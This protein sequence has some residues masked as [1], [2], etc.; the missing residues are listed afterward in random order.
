MRTKV[1]PLL[2]LGFLFVATGALYAGPRF[3]IGIGIG[4]PV[5]AYAPPPPPP[6]YGYGY[7]YAYA[8]PPSPGPGYVWIGGYYYPSGRGYLWAPGYWTRRPFVGAVY[9]GP[10]WVNHRYY[11]GYWRR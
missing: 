5:Y 10:R 3:S 6:V 11:H 8:P 4:A 9:V 2:V 7:G 1:L